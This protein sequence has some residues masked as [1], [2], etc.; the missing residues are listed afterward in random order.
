MIRSGSTPIRTGLSENGAIRSA[1]WA[2]AGFAA[3]IVFWHGVGFWALVSTAVLSGGDEQ[4]RA[5]NPL[6]RSV[7]SSRK[8]V[9]TASVARPAQ[10]GCIALTFNRSRGET[11]ALPCAGAALHHLDGGLGYKSDKQTGLS[12]LRISQ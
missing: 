10:S 5:T 1:L 11:I 12:V 3:G 7:T 8:P 2:G 6:P 4:K 9:E